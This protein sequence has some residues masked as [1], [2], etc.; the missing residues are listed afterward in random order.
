[1]KK[2]TGIFMMAALAAV[3]LTACTQ[4]DSGNSSAGAGN[5]ATAG[6]GTIEATGDNAASSGTIEQSAGTS[7]ETVVADN[8]TSDG[9]VAGTSDGATAGTADGAGTAE[10][11]ADDELIFEGGVSVE[12]EIETDASVDEEILSDEELEAMTED[13]NAAM[14]DDGWVGSYI[15]EN[16]EILTVSAVDETT[17]TFA[18][19]NAGIAGTAE[20][21][22]NQAVYHGDD[23]HVAVF[24]YSGTDIQVSVLSEEDYDASGSPLNGVYVRQ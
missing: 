8:G 14:Q 23:Y 13:P 4:A 20:L 16:E 11:V 2:R 24:D 5:A 22:G 6:S 21:N 15:N 1:M 19:T 17:I 12:D 3:V 10:E 9:A 7:E 18:F